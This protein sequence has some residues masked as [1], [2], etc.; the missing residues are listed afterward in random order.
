MNE[1]QPPADRSVDRSAT[2][3]EPSVEQAT[4]TRDAGPE[5][6]GPES[7][8]ALVEELEPVDEAAAAARA[9]EV[10][11]AFSEDLDPETLAFGAPK[12]L[13]IVCQWC[14]GPLESDDLEVCPHCG[15]RLRPT[16]EDLVVPGVTTL[17]SEAARALELAEI[18]RNREAAKTGAAM[19]TAPSLASASAVVPAPDE[20]TVEA[21]NR[22]PDEEVRRLMREM[23]IEARQARAMASA[24]A[25]V[26]DGP[27]VEGDQGAGSG[28][29]TEPDAG[30]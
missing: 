29:A 20:A 11:M 6:L 23:E 21:A 25:D 14:N 18:Q 7:A 27:A 22:P 9:D 15:S 16:E 1:E 17:S 4:D 28:E 5:A 24:R 13:T 2:P 10:D 19:Y 3:A 30:R 12:P 8:E 26:E